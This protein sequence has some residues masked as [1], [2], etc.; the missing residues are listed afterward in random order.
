MATNP[1]R[2]MLAALNTHAVDKELFIPY[3]LR[4]VVLL[5][6]QRIVVGVIGLE[7]ED[8]EVIKVHPV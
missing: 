2:L 1:I 6:R 5:Q 8:D 4:C 7:I 3:V